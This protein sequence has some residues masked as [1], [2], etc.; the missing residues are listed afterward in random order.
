MIPEL[1]QFALIVALLL[2]ITA[3]VLPLVG[4]AR[5]ITNWTRSAWPL[6]RAQCGFVTMAFGCLAVS[7]MGNDFSVA[8]V[9]SNSNSMLPLIYR[10]AAV[11]GGHE[12]SLLLWTLLL[13]W[14]MAV[15]SV[16]SKQLPRPMV[17]RV[18]GVMSWINV[19]FLLFMLWTSNPFTR[20]C[21]R[22]WM[23]AISTRCCKTR[24]WSRI[25]PFFIWGTSASP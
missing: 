11:W 21:H 22:Q 13:T 2:A 7:F 18:L 17:A 15:V 8:Y 19:G 20:L 23:A 10:F 16:F 3:G 14:W 9:A 25:R 24:A 4:A 6:A 12:G 5:G 1:G